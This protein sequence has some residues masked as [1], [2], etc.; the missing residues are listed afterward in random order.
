MSIAPL[1]TPRIYSLLRCSKLL[2]SLVLAQLGILSPAVA[3]P[4]RGTLD[5]LASSSLPTSLSLS[6]RTSDGMHTFTFAPNPLEDGVDEERHFIGSLRRHKADSRRIRASLSFFGTTGFLHFSS[7]RRH[8]LHSV[9]FSLVK[10]SRGVGLDK[11]RISSAPLLSLGCAVEA[12]NALKASNPTAQSASSTTGTRTQHVNAA[13]VLEVGAEADYAFFR[14]F[15]TQTRNYIRAALRAADTLYTSELGIR[16]KLTSLRVTNQG[17]LQASTVTAEN[18][19]ET[20]RQQSQTLAVPTD[21]RHLF[22]G[23]E[24]DGYTIGVAYVGTA[25]WDEERFNVGVSRAVN[26]ALQ[27]VL[28]AH[29]IGHN[30]NAVHD[31]GKGSVMNP[32][33]RSRPASFSQAARQDIQSFIESFG[34]CLG[35]TEASSR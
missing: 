22:T 10:K 13:R 33:P 19:L 35:T 17:S 7:R 30:L 3:A 16:I 31:N 9:Q 11:V 23:R 21:V 26:R 1:H 29:E 28:A 12:H 6:V 8:R 20:F 15:G 27:P 25:C 4:M 5:K 32:A 34:A 2:V 14:K 24:L 18:V